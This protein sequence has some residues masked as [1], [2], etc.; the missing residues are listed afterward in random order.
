M[1]IDVVFKEM[2]STDGIRNRIEERA[3]K[4]ESLVAPDDYVRV[5][6]QAQFKGQQHTAEIQWH[7]NILKQD[8]HAK[9]EGHDLYQQIDQVIDKAYRQLRTA[10]DRLSDARKKQEPA[11][12]QIS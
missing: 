5:V 6:V 7:D 11:K 12:R 1:K 3:R 9:A 10:H 8:I 4:L 2:D